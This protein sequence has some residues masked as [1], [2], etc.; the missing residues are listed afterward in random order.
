[1]FVVL[2]L[3]LIPKSIPTM[4]HSFNSMKLK[5][6]HQP[7]EKLKCSICIDTNGKFLGIPVKAE[8]PIINNHSLY[9]YLQISN[10]SCG[11]KDITPN[12]HVQLSNQTFDI[13][14][15]THNSIK[16]IDI[17]VLSCCL[18]LAVLIMCCW[19]HLKNNSA[20]KT[21]V[22]ASGE[23]LH[24]LELSS[25]DNSHIEIEVVAP[26]ESSA[27]L[28]TKSY[29]MEAVEEGEFVWPGQCFE[30]TS[31]ASIPSAAS[32]VSTEVDHGVTC[33]W[34]V[35]SM[36]SSFESQGSMT[37]LC[38]S[39][40]PVLSSSTSLVNY[41]AQPRLTHDYYAA[42]HTPAI[43]FPNLMT[44]MLPPTAPFFHTNHSHHKETFLVTVPFGEE[45][46]TN[47]TS[48]TEQD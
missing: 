27:V 4:G 14:D 37:S 23:N 1:M 42:I 24:T 8:D 22:T 3:Y 26:V 17:P 32:D 15:V 34:E 45:P 7:F 19:R 48:V 47:N 16:K 11:I 20:K 41:H 40:T 44:R 33:T 12:Q 9:Q 30:D 39:P 21:T 13:N 35:C 36:D 25:S 46:S 31:G 6:Y 5:N 29:R 18:F 10:Q 28:S 2:T 38:S 43:M